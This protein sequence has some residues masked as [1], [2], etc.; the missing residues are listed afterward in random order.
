MRN[1]SKTLKIEQTQSVMEKIKWLIQNSGQSEGKSAR[2]S[3]SMRSTSYRDR[4]QDIGALRITKI[5]PLIMKART[6]IILSVSKR[7]WE[8]YKLILIGIYP[9]S[10]TINYV[11]IP[12]FTGGI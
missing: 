1:I 7:K 11:N 10:W 5:N 3:R 6:I 12:T 2:N 8:I 9:L 4:G